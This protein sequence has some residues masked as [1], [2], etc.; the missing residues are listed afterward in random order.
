[1]ASERLRNGGGFDDVVAD[2]RFG[3]R[4]A[5][6]NPLIAAACIVT[7]AIGLGMNTAIFS[8]V[9]AVLLRPLPFPDSNRLVL[10]S[11]YK[12]GNVAKTGS[13]LSRYRE[14][15]AEARSFDKTGGYWDVS[16]GN[17]M[18]FGVG[19]AERIQ[20]SIVTNS[21][22]SI[23][24]VQPRVGRLFSASE[25]EP[26]AAKVFLASDR[27]WR[28]A[29]GG[30]L[31]AVG[32]TFRLDGELYTLIGVMPADFHFPFAC[33]VWLPIGALGAHALDDRVSHQFWMIGRLRPGATIEQAQT[34]LNTIQERLAHDHPASDSN[35]RVRVTPLLDEFVGNVRA[36]L[37]ALFAAVGF[38]LLIACTNIVN[39][40]LAHAVA[41]E[42]E[43]AVRAA[44]GA[45]RARLIRQALT[46]TLIIV[47]AGGAVAWLL[48]R[49]A[50][51]A[52]ARLAHGSIP[53]IDQLHLGAP[54]LIFSVALVLAVTLLIGIA[55]G[56]H[57]SGIAFAE[58]L[59]S[60]QRTSVSRHSTRTRNLLV[61]SEVTLTVVLLSAAGLMLRSLQRLRAVDPGFRPEQLV[62]MKI[63]LP[64]A[65]YTTAAQRS[66][67]LQRLLERLD[68]TPG[69]SSA[70]ATDRLP[71]SGERNWGAFNIVGRPLLDSAHAPVVEGRAVSTKYF[72]TV[73]IPLL[74][75]REFTD[76]DVAGNRHVAIINVAM[77]QKFWPGADPIGARLQSPYHPN[78][79]PDE[80]VGVVG[81]VKDFALDADSP[82]EIYRPVRWWNVVNLVLQS[83]LDMQ[84]PVAAA[85]REAAELD[86]NVP[87]YDVA[88]MADLLD[89]S[90]ARGWLE[91]LLV[92]S[93]AAIS[94]ALAAIGLYGV[95][96]FHVHRR[97]SE[98]GIRLALG[99]SPRRVLALVVGQGM[100]LVLAGL[101]AGIGATLL[102]T[103]L[104][105]GLLFQVS[106]SD[107][108]TLMV[109]AVL[110][111]A[112]GTLACLLPARRAMLVD[113]I[114]ALRAE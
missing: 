62:T 3:I 29:L 27:V 55:P 105:R 16:G 14:R 37:W 38:V 33:D 54:A 69:I 45:R 94:L 89:H 49:L 97:T 104:I 39:L 42:Q 86:P 56:L 67:F 57:A 4:Q 80:I 10:V 101:I 2:V 1:M 46:E 91:L 75:G 12:P 31:A 59:Q 72:Q 51:V 52:V 64:D 34:E 81:N 99:A 23:V 35:W 112:V 28:S 87:V 107:P 30:D 18:V 65:L 44:L 48:A 43:F 66:A 15:A 108:T 111:V 19:S 26:G 84:S 110:L 71:L 25:E 32:K 8:T 100:R 95:L 74:R 24:G 113:P 7:L 82:P 6:R 106:P 102:L 17:G 70:A 68:A 96:A 76:A 92:G 98:I 114:I 20:F 79:E 103:R 93:F 11:E 9:Y 21:F 88:P 40:L 61:V 73:K 5:W 90:I 109:V 58:S 47:A 50:V 13:P 77:A 78:D 60:G 36:S 85:R 53:R 41:R 22:F 83:S 63:A